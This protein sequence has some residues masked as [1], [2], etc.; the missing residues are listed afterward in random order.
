ML[1]IHLQ[2]NQRRIQMCFEPRAFKALW[3]MWWE[4]RLIFLE[5]RGNLCNFLKDLYCEITMGVTPVCWGLWHLHPASYSGDSSRNSVTI[6]KLGDSH[7]KVPL[8]WLWTL[9]SSDVFLCTLMACA[10]LPMCLCMC[11]LRKLIL[12]TDLTSSKIKMHHHK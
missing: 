1:L 7:D 11:N 12:Y 5:D 8:T 10:F 4:W 6:P 2:L 9:F 3:I